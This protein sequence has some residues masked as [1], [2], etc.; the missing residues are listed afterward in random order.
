[1]NLSYECKICVQPKPMVALIYKIANLKSLSVFG[2][3]AVQFLIE[4]ALSKHISCLQFYN[5]FTNKSIL[6][7]ETTWWTLN[8]LTY[9]SR[10]HNVYRIRPPQNLPFIVITVHHLPISS[11]PQKYTV[12]CRT[13]DNNLSWDG[14]HGDVAM[15]INQTLFSTKSTTLNP[16]VKP[17]LVSSS[18]GTIHFLFLQAANNTVWTKK[19]VLGRRKGSTSYWFFAPSSCLLRR[20]RVKLIFNLSF[21]PHWSLLHLQHSEVTRVLL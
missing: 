15:P 17:D 19:K 12:K 6:A 16:L 20:S 8:Y 9:H 14:F 4:S 18:D 2:L 1:M 11:F 3:F 7:S 10:P 13:A 21:R 5:S